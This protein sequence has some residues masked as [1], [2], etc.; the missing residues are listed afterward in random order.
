MNRAAQFCFNLNFVI[1][2]GGKKKGNWEYS[3]KTAQIFT[4]FLFLLLIHNLEY[5]SELI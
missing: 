4:L 2:Q 1:L 3:K 5:I